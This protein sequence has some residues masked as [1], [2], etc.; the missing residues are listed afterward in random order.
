MSENNSPGD[1]KSSAQWSRTYYSILVL[2]VLLIPVITILA[3]FALG[4]LDA[5]INGVPIFERMKLPELTRF[6]FSVV[7]AGRLVLI[8]VV[9]EFIIIA[10]WLFR[11]SI[12]SVLFSGMSLTLC[13]LFMVLAQISAL[14]PYLT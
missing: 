9:A 10:L 3:N 1:L 8:A 12:L 2:S 5:T 13:I 7:G 14:L 6:Y 11:Q 4:T